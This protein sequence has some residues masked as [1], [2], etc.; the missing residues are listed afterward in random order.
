MSALIDSLK[1]ANEAGRKKL[2]GLPEALHQQ[3]TQEF[4]GKNRDKLVAKMISATAQLNFVTDILQRL[5]ASDVVVEE[6]SA[7]DQA[8]LDELAN[9]L[10]QAI[11]NDANTDALLSTATALLTKVAELGALDV[12]ANPTPPPAAMIMLAGAPEGDNPANPVAAAASFDDRVC[13]LVPSRDTAQDWT[14]ADALTANALAA[15]LA[16]P[17]AVDLRQPWWTIGNQFNT[18]ACVGWATADG[19]MRYHLVQADRLGQNERLSPRFVWMASKETDEFTD[20]PSTFIEE[21][22]T[23]LKNAMDVVRKYGTV[24]DNMLPFQINT[25]M[26]PGTENAL[27]AAASTRRAANYFNLHR[28][29]SQWKAWLANNGPILVGLNVDQTWDDAALTGGNLDVYQ[30]NTVRGGHAVCIVG[31][32][33]SRF[34]IRNSW[35]TEWGDNGFGYALPA[36][37]D[38]GFFDEAYGVT[39]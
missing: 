13:N 7:A 36:Y 6:I 1:A 39:L 24:L 26:Y 3:L 23:S 19:I 27:Y 35:G 29:F 5:E 8:R 18:G 22:G 10:D 34:I 4:N 11:I 37:I 17:P 2:V 33:R 14:L 32:T 30:P 21:A 38:A 15:P 25:L 31:Y 9:E 20:R 28:N 16:L 12:K